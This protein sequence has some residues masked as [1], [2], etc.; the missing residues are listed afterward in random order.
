MKHHML[1]VLFY[2]IIITSV[3][4]HVANILQVLSVSGCFSYEMYMSDSYF[5]PNYSSVTQTLLILQRLNHSILERE[6]ME[7]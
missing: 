1:L 6:L 7:I 2:I 5:D 3:C 4:R